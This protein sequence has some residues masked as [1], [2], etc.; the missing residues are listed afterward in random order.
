MSRVLVIDDEADIRELI[1]LTLVRM[2]LATEC[3]GSVAE[4]R[5]ALD[6]AVFQ[7]CLTDM[8][9][10]DGD[11]LEIVR[12][13]TEHHPQTPIAVITAYGSAENAVAALKAGA[14]DYLAK[15]VGLEQLRS[16]IKSALRLPGGGQDSENPLQSLIG[17]SPSMQQV[18]AMIEKL[19]RSQ[20]PIY[21][22]G[23]SGSGKELAARLIHGR[24]ARAAGTF[25]PV[26]CGAIPEN[27]MESEFFGYRKGAF[28]GADSEREGFFQAAHGGTLFLDEVADLPLAMQVKL[29]RA[30]QEKRV[31]KVGSVAEEPVDVRII[32]ATHKNLRELVDRGAFRQDLYYRLNVI[33]LR[34]PPLRERMEDIAPLVEAI[35][36]RVF[37]DSPPKLSSGA[38]KALSFYSFPGNVR[39]LENILERATALCSDDLIEAE[40]LHL[41]PEEMSGSEEQGRGSETLDEYLNRLER[42][43]I[44]EALQKSEGN[45]TAAARLLGVT[46]RSM[47]YRLERLG[48]E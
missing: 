8:R 2:G 26:N 1:D 23:E 4:A 16:L 22:S 32:C 40:D 3:V 45:R 34:M 19:A 39:E 36:R 27:L 10:P 41:G 18:R 29:L 5:T 46:F 17:D 33:E 31:R 42:Q 44:L 28:T 14:F 13:I 25:V 12:Y 9:L 37:G 11:G 35:L 7:L 47:R 15:P 24:S 6:N 21:I 20:A 38:V 30:I 43:A 48:I